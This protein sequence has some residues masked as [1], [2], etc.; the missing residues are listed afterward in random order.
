M[1]LN[2]KYEYYVER[3][4]EWIN[5]KDLATEA[6]Q[7]FIQNLTPDETEKAKLH[8]S[9][10]SDIPNYGVLLLDF[11]KSD[12]SWNKNE[13]PYDSPYK[14]E[15]KKRIEIADEIQQRF[16]SKMKKDEFTKKVQFRNFFKL[17]Y[18]LL[19]LESS[20][21]EIFKK[22]TSQTVDFSFDLD[23]NRLKK[24]AREICNT[25]NLL[26]IQ[27]KTLMDQIENYYKLD[28]Y[29]IYSK[30]GMRYYSRD[31]KKEYI[32][33]H[34]KYLTID[35]FVG[36]IK[37]VENGTTVYK[38]NPEAVEIIFTLLKER[39]LSF[40][41]HVRHFYKQYAFDSYGKR[42][43]HLYLTESGSITR[44]LFRKYP[45]ILKDFTRVRNYIKKTYN[46]IH[47]TSLDANEVQLELKNYQ[48]R[49]PVVN[50]IINQL[51][52]N[53]FG[54]TNSELQVVADYLNY[55]DKEHP[56]HYYLPSRPRTKENLVDYTGTLVN[57]KNELN[58]L[59]ATSSELELH[60][61]YLSN[62]ED[63]VR[64]LLNQT[65]TSYDTLRKN[66]R[67][68]LTTSEL[69]ELPEYLLI[70]LFDTDTDLKVMRTKIATMQQYL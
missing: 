49:Y 35:N 7:L 61:T 11:E 20:E 25:T 65:K 54:F 27:A 51:Q 39:E 50:E 2:V 58:R 3:Y 18:S 45:Q 13:L 47:E 33:P 42:V 24:K 23:L 63:F 64:E 1:S 30:N 16:L 5:E 52:K 4:R 19:I 22:S 10:E 17:V 12:S 43:I 66:F 6:F 15:I 21:L 28:G 36:K 70:R 14:N 48:N 59:G 26:Y 53:I 32:F 9:D 67:N 44:D 38:S 46:Q 57:F 29:H 68:L 41:E 60:I 34:S 56:F 62:M 8:L 55:F 31:K 69:L 37:T 40:Y